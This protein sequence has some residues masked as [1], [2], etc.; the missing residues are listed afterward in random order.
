M[1]PESVVA[2]QVRHLLTAIGIAIA[3]KKGIDQQYIPMIVGLFMAI[4]G[5]L[6]SAWN[7]KQ[8]SARITAALKLDPSSTRA[9]LEEAIQRSAVVKSLAVIGVLLLLPLCGHAQSPSPTPQVAN[10]HVVVGGAIYRGAQPDARGLADLKALGV[11]TV[12]DLRGFDEVARKEK[13]TCDQLGLRFYS[14][15]LSGIWAP[16]KAKEEQVQAILADH[17]Q[18]PVYLHCRLGKDRTGTAYALFRM[19]EQCWS[20]DSAVSEAYLI[21]MSRR[22]VF[23]RAY[24]KKQIHRT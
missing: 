9:D 23:M 17:S 20:Y 2:G 13:A 8:V 12:I 5:S 16:D 1:Q 22:D 6:W 11:R 14:F 15:P 3:T 7:K 4:G 19:R 21:G 24:L 10:F 18:W